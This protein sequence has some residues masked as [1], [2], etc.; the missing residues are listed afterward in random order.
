MPAKKYGLVL[1]NPVMSANEKYLSS[2]HTSTH[3]IQSVMGE[4]EFSNADHLLALREER[5]DG[6]KNQD[7]VNGAKL[8]KLV[9]DLDY[10]DRRPILRSKNTVAWLNVHVTTVTGTVLDSTEFRDFY[11]HAMMLP[12]QHS[13]QIRWLWHIIRCTSHT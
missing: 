13:E 10:T 11:A 4:G 9:A 8:K 2:Q 5:C 12:P 6:Q 7:D 3:L 1:L